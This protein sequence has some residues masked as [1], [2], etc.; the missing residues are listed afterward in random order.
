METVAAVFMYGL[1]I[2]F[3]GMMTWFFGRKEGRLSKFVALLM[4][5]ICVGYMKDF[6][7]LVSGLFQDDFYWAVMTSLDII[8]VPMYGFILMELVR[9][10]MVTKR[11]I[12]LHESLFLL[13]MV[14][15]ISL[16]IVFFYY[17]LVSLAAVYGTFLLIWTTFQIPKYNR[18]LCER[19]SY[20]ENINLNWLRV[21]LYTFYLILGLW[22]LAS[23]VIHLEIECAYM[24]GT[25][26]FWMIIDFFI[27]KHES[28]MEELQEEPM[29]ETIDRTAHESGAEASELSRRITVLFKERQLFL[30]PHLKVSDVAR[31]V[32]TNRTYVSNYFNHEERTTFYDYVNSLR[33]DYSCR[34]L[35]TTEESIKSIA[36][37]SGFNSASSYIRVFTKQKGMTPN[38]YRNQR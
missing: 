25:L 29:P 33:V 4:G 19:F 28:V 18:Q 37:S 7:F 22:I 36:E 17:A 38:V 2:M 21:I 1:C 9:P 5:T 11:W 8:A 15:F 6:G 3:Y 16:R 34:L 14:L 10:G 26:V 35:E 13:L 20:T 27:Y 23:T 24:L 31:A 32:G 30:N 12:M